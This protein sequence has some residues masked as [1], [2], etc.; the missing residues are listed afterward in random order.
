MPTPRPIGTIF[1]EDHSGLV[2]SSNT[3][4]F[5]VTWKVVGHVSD[6]DDVREELE[7]VSLEY[8]DIEPK[9]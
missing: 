4:P 7:Q 9:Q 2:C 1:E 3:R 5:V 6:G 8:I